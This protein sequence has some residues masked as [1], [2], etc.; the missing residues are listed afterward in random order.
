[1]LQERRHGMLQEPRYA[2]LPFQPQ[3][4]GQTLGG[5]PALSFACAWRLPKKLTSRPL[6]GSV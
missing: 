2:M 4:L 6:I 5:A 3:I 1:M